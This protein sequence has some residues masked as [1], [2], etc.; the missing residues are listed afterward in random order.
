MIALIESEHIPKVQ[1]VFYCQKTSNQYDCIDIKRA[2][3]K[4]TVIVL[5]PVNIE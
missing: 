3:P 2:Y 5:L 1:L 4:S